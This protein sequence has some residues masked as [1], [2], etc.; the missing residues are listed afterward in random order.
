MLLC[1]FPVAFFAALYLNKL[2][3]S[4]RAAICRSFT[5]PVYYWS[6]ITLG[7]RLLISLMQFLQVL[8]PNVVSFLRMLLST[9]ML[10]LLVHLRP[11]AFTHV[12]WLDVSCYI[13]LIAQFGLQMIFTERDYLLVSVADEQLEFHEKMTHLSLIIRYV[14]Q[15]LHFSLC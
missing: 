9:G 5:E 15:Y 7:F 4:A 3:Q 12:F 1:F 11:H 14:Q 8:Y 10:F 2:P 13:C 6:A